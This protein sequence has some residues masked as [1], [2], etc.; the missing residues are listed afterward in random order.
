MKL[1]STFRRIPK[2]RRIILNGLSIRLFLQGKTTLLYSFLD[3]N[4]SPRET[5]VLEYSFGRKSNQKQGIEKT[6]CHVWEYGGKLDILKNIM[7]S[8]PLHGRYYYCIMLDLSKIKQLW[9]TLE[10]C[11][12]L[13]WF[14]KTED[15]SDSS[16]RK[17]LVIIGGKYDLFQNYGQYV[18]KYYL[19]L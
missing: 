2:C 18:T 16:A 10:T 9:N 19:Y 14:E 17:D 15:H 6:I 12:Q 8:I 3:K 7:P 5:L 11:L 13:E 1:Q 4:D